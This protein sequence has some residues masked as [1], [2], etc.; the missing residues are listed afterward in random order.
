MMRSAAGFAV[1]KLTAAL[2]TVAVVPSALKHSLRVVNCTYIRVSQ[3]IPAHST[4]QSSSSSVHLRALH[5]TIYLLCQGELLFSGIQL[6]AR[7]DASNDLTAFAQFM[8]AYSRCP[9]EL[10]LTPPASWDATHKMA[11]ARLKVD[12]H[13]ISA[14]YPCWL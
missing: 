14:A 8:D 12:C 5:M 1:G 2:R 6:K 9:K 4:V 3:L 13:I 10:N 11:A 7:C